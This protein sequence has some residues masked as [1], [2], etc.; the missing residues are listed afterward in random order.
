MKILYVV[1]QFLPE[2]VGGTENYVA[3]LAEA[4]LER[5]RLVQVFHGSLS[6]SGPGEFQGLPV[7]RTRGTFRGALRDRIEAELWLHNPAALQDFD[8]LLTSWQPALVHVHH[9]AGLT[10]ALIHHAADQGRPVVVTLHDYWAFCANA[11]L[12]FRGI[13]RGPWYGLNCAACALDRFGANWALPGTPLLAPLFVRRQHLLRQALGRASQLIAPS[14]FVADTFVAQGYPADRLAVIPHG[15]S[16]PPA[17]FASQPGDGRLRLLYLGG[18]TSQKG[19]HILVEAVNRLPPSALTLTIHGDE[20]TD[21]AYARSL[22]AMITHSSI[23]L[24][25]PASPADIW[26]ALARADLVVVPSLWPETFSLVASEAFAAGVPV[27]AS[28][29]GALAEKVRDRVDGL[30]FRPGDAA[31]LQATIQRLVAQPEL[32]ARLR[33]GIQPPQPMARH[34]AELERLYARFILS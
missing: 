17:D 23:I 12:V 31:D 9:L 1:H 26:E 29:I 27:V 11:Q 3:Q 30:L 20:T 25:G 14:R 19:V 10:P 16:T 33:Q 13:C 15:I 21:P 24:A 8:R 2:R 4:M 34:A 22:R 32:L 28:R 7:Y 5:G 6:T 18:L